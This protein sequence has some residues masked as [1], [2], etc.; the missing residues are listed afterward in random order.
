MQTKKY[1]KKI[2]ERNKEDETGEKWHQSKAGLH[3]EIKNQQFIL[4]VDQ[5]S[6]RFVITTETLKFKSF[7]RWQLK[8][9][10]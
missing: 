6:I 5:T 2:K 10:I 1:I 4:E 8:N 7:S 3:S 9:I